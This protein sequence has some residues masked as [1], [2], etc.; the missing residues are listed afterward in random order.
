MRV[1]EQGGVW[2]PEGGGVSY[3]WR[4]T[5]QKAIYNPQLE[6]VQ[7]PCLRE[8][9]K[10]QALGGSAHPARPTPYKEQL[11]DRRCQHKTKTPRPIP[12]PT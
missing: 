3:R 10:R 11:R 5:T 2:R 8:G 7:C 12:L 9:P 1:T 4:Q 6:I